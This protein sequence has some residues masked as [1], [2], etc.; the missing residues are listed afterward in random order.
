V[1]ATTR[2]PVDLSGTVTGGA[3][4]APIAGARVTLQP[5][6][7][8]GP[9]AERTNEEG[10]FEFQSL[11]PGT[12]MVMASASG[13]QP[14]EQ[15]V[16]VEGLPPV[17]LEIHLVPDGDEEGA[18]S[19][20]IQARPDP[21]QVVGFYH[22]RERE[23]GSF[24]VAADIRRRG[25]GTPAELV[26]SLPGFR[27]L[28]QSGIVVGRRGCSPSLFIDG[29]DAGDLRQIN[30]LVSVGNISALEAYPGSSPPAMFA[31]L[32]SQCGAVVVWTPRG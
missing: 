10:S 27:Q 22:R 14:L 23:S 30:F 20:T 24:L 17:R 28:P 5:A 3:E 15:R 9:A 8:N 25:V 13:Y 29:L 26:L 7:G 32:N 4:G 19:A 2:A 6:S 12:Y 18:S 31:G 11:A 21:L 1:G 16:E